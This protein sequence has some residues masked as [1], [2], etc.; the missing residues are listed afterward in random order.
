M[1]TLQRCLLLVL[2]FFLYFA[3][4]AQLPCGFGNISA[5]EEKIAQ[6]L[7][8]QFSTNKQFNGSDPVYIAVKP[9]FVTTDA[10]VTNMSMAAFN[11]AIAICNQYFINA[12]IQFY[13]CGTPAN[14]P[15][16]INSTAMY[17]WQ[18][19][20]FKQD[21]VTSANNVTN[22]H[23]IYFSNSLGGVGG[24][25]YGSTQNRAYNNSFSLNSQADDNKTLAHELGHYFNLAHTFNNSGATNPNDRERVTR[26]PAEVSPRLSAN[27]SSTGDY[28]CDTPADPYNLSGGKLVGC[29]SL[30][31]GISIL[32]AN[33]DP[34]VP[35]AYNVMNYYFC[36]PYDFTPL[37]YARMNTALAINNTPSSN[38]ATRYTLDCAETPQDAPSNVAASLISN[39]VSL[40]VLIQW[41]DNSSNETGYIIERSTSPTDNF[42]AI[43]GVDANVT[44]FK[45]LKTLIQQTYYYRVKASNTKANYNTTIPTV[46][47]PAIC[48]PQYSNGC[49]VNANI[50]NFSITNSNGTT[51]LSNLGSGCSANNFGDYTNLSPASV[52]AGTTYNFTMNTA[53][54]S[55]GY[56]F[57]EHVGIWIDANQNNSYS[58]AGELVFQSSGTVMSGTTEL[59]GSFTVPA[60]ANTGAIRLRIRS[61]IKSEGLVDSPCGIFGTGETEDYLLNVNPSVSIT[62]SIPTVCSSNNTLSVSF[63]SNFTANNDN[64]YTVQLSDAT[65]NFSNATTVGSGTNS[66]IL[67]TIPTNTP[68]GSS[69]K[70]RVNSSSPAVIG[71][72]TSGF[73]Y[74]E[75]TANIS[76]SGRDIINSGMS[77]S[78]L[79]TFTGAAP[80][81]YTL[82]NGS[83][84]SGITSQSVNINITPSSTTSYTLN[85]ASGGCG[86]ATISAGTATV[87]V[88][89]YCIPLYTNNCSPTATTT[90][91]AINQV[92]LK[93]ANGQLLLNNDNSNCSTYE[94]SDFTSSSALPVPLLK[95]DSTYIFFV[96]AYLSSDG[97]YYP[98][99]FTVWIDYNNN[100]SFADAGELVFQSTDSGLSATGTFTIPSNAS[101][102]TTRMRVRSRY[103]AAA[104]DACSSHS[105]GEGEDYAVQ[106]SRIVSVGGTVAG[107]N[108]SVCPNTD[109]NVQLSLS[110]QTGT[111]LK[112]QSAND[113]TFTS[114]I[115]IT[116]TTATQVVST[117]SSTTYFRAIVKNGVAPEVSSAFARIM[118]NP[119]TSIQ[120]GNW[121]D[122]STWNLGRIPQQDDFVT[123]RSSDTVYINTD[124]AQ[125][126]C[127]YNAQDSQLIYGNTSGKL[128]LGN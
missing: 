72:E 55:A 20:G 48:G 49:L 37:Q 87:S 79:L 58:D 66:P 101:I 2:F 21:S 88:I 120:S 26:N 104:T 90:K 52:K 22:A 103:G 60:S 31:T 115:D 23:N 64:L 65:G 114:P 10:G 76:V 1:K 8:K 46:S 32:D 25:S 34:F 110:S 81:S 122:T 83:S 45:D 63:L 71:S 124:S 89:P 96:K 117:V 12:G 123:I 125:A 105:N 39:S 53:L 108:I 50:T 128:T 113:S 47:T 11:N 13:I 42:V 68:A 19:T 51:L 84:A 106:I 54:S 30:G 40:G 6:Q 4:Y 62:T 17:N 70:L 121:E 3:G 77:S 118:V 33:N 80:Y 74:G 59:S 7:I 98:Q 86:T 73:G 111:I 14:T 82:S 67:V 57:P 43:G 56:Y 119:I 16:Y 102:G 94:F 28:L 41:T 29:N 38:P 27:C 75:S 127:L 5:E 97:Y 15:N 99:Y 9:H 18:T 107:G 85:T 44:S 92:T 78:L 116:N 126:K 61:R 69:Y 36:Q 95:G 91:M 109:I 93:K 24:F 100:N 35:S 112:W